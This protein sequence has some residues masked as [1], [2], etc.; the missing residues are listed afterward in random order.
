MFLHYAIVR[1]IY[2]AHYAIVH[3]GD[4]IGDRKGR[5]TRHFKRFIKSQR[6]TAERYAVHFII[7]RIKSCNIDVYDTLCFVGS[8]LCNFSAGQ[9][10]NNGYIRFLSVEHDD[11]TTTGKT[12]V[13]QKDK[14]KAAY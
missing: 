11:P 10:E 8:V 12:I 7:T 2:V 13:E 14:R 4:S 3:C 6:E 1:V 5:N 9:K